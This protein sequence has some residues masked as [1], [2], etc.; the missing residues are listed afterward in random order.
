MSSSDPLS[1]PEPDEI[2]ALSIEFSRT[3]V[4]WM[5]DFLREIKK[6]N[7]IKIKRPQLLRALL[8]VVKDMQLDPCCI[9]GKNDLLDNIKRRLLKN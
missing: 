3:Q 8:E 5:D 1:R 9:K 2:E 7:G 6:R 4:E